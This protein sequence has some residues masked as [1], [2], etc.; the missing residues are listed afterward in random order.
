MLLNTEKLLAAKPQTVL[1]P[2]PWN[3]LIKQARQGD[4]EAVKTFCKNA[5][6]ILRP[7]CNI[8]Y[9]VK[10][11][12][13]DEIQ[14]TLYLIMMEFLMQYPKSLTDEEVPRL[15][16]RILRNALLNQIQ[17]EATRA[18]YMQ[19]VTPCYEPAE[20]GDEETEIE[21]YIADSAE[22]PENQ[23]LRQELTQAVKDA[24]YYLRPSEHNV[25]Y[26]L[27]FEHKT[28]AEL[29]REMHCTTQNICRLHKNGLRHLRKLLAQ[30]M[31][32][33]L[34]SDLKDKLM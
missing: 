29:A 14:S 25:L 15:L 5:K 4:E 28:N 34:L 23:L 6:V 26:G 13:R 3:L 7:F 21:Q 24:M 27:Y 17:K 32:S 22:E 2:I 10:K 8:P 16:K 30:Q 33:P 1:A 20:M 11:L 12:G 9:F 19:A 18:K 31:A